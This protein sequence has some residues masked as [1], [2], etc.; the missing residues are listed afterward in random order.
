VVVAAV[1]IGLQ[2]GHGWILACWWVALVVCVGSAG[3]LWAAIIEHT[4]WGRRAG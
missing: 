3:V 2:L 1:P 4:E